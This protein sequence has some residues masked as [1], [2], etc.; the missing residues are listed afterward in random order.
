MGPLILI[1]YGFAV[2]VVLVSL[3]SDFQDKLIAVRLQAAGSLLTGLPTIDDSG[4]GVIALVAE[5]S[6]VHSEYFKAYLGTSE[7]IVT[8]M[9]NYIVLYVG[10]IP[11]STTSLK[12]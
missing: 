2:A 7:V 6:L 12:C 10:E 4:G 1:A 11:L 3:T 9:M 5:E 8:I